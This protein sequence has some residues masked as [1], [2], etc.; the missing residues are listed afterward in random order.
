MENHDVHSQSARPNGSAFRV[1]TDAPTSSVDAPLRGR[2][3]K[4]L[5]VLPPSRSI[6]HHIL[7]RSVDVVGSVC[8]A[9]LLSPLILTL[10]IAV[11]AGGGPIFFGHTRVGREK[12]PFKC[13][14]FRSMIPDAE[15]VLQDL[16]HSDP[17]ALQ[18]WRQNHKLKDDPRVTRFGSFLRKSSLDELPQLWNVFKGDMSLV[19]PRPIVAD[20]LE[21]YGAKAHMYLAVKPGMT[22]LWQVMGRSSV[23]YSRRVSMDSLYARK[24]S[25]RLDVWILFKTFGAVVRKVGA[26]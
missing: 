19:G 8:I 6:G 25:L 26:H 10:L 11:R 5:P 7:K 16:L 20:E 15:R 23:T 22:G 2:A 24:K 18:E 3:R 9:I 13:Y 17:E 21:R 1:A 4:R 12:K 14:K